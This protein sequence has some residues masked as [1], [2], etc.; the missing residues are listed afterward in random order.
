MRKNEKKNQKHLKKRLGSALGRVDAQGFG[1]W[2]TPL[3]QCE[4]AAPKAISYRLCADC[5]A[6]R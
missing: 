6:A 2:A 5:V 3:A 4:A 1:I